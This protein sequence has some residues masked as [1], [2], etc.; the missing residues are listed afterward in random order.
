M[1]TAKTLI[2]LGGCHFVDIVMRRLKCFD[3]IIGVYA[4]NS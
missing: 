1:R 2:R 3:A 4:E